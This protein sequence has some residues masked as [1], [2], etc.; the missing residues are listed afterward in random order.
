MRNPTGRNIGISL[1]YFFSILLTACTKD[2]GLQSADQSATASSPNTAES[3][4]PPY[5]L[6]P[7]QSWQPVATGRGVIS[8]IASGL[9]FSGNNQGQFYAH[10]QVVLPARQ[11]FKV[12]V[13]VNY[14][15]NDYSP[16]GIYIMDTAMVN[17]IGEFEKVYSSGSGETWEFV[18][19]SKTA[20]PV[21]LV[22]GF[23]NG[24]N[25]KAA[26]TKATITTFRYQPRISAAGLS[27]YLSRKLDLDFT[28][29]QYDTSIC[30]ISDYVNSVLLCRY[31][32][33]ADTVEQPILNNLIG[34]DTAYAYFNDYRNT[35]DSITDSYCQKSSLSLGE[36]LTNAF[37]I[38]VRQIYMVIG[39]VGLHQ[40][41]EYWNPFAEKWII[42]DPC[43]STRY[44]KDGVLLGDQD[45]D[46]QTAPGFI[47]R[48][49]QYYYYQTLDPLVQLWQQLQVLDVNDYYTITFPYL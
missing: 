31:E 14:T 10:Q 19:Y 29:R 47:T 49:G 26:F 17:T 24:M 9:E 16:A 22:I 6:F 27:N 36:I 20:G 18:F 13:T 32:Y 38:P 33:Y 11:F 21:S 3:A 23:L 15:I 12:S 34:A 40:F 41:Q 35:P 45:I 28:A 39:G 2:P 37:N 1:L 5:S 8:T 42:I 44:I 48:F 7:L 46:S 25:G 43:F 30:K 4:L